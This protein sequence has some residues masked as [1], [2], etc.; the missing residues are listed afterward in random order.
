MRIAEEHLNKVISNGQ[1]ATV[2]TVLFKKIVCVCVHK[3]YRYDVSYML[4]ATL[5]CY[6]IQTFII[7][8]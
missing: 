4:R 7:S 6:I 3:I 8:T 1:T 2:W 5:Q